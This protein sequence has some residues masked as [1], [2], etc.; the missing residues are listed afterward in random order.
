MSTTHTRDNTGARA[1]DRRETVETKPA[2]KT[3]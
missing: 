2:F 3:S 1:I